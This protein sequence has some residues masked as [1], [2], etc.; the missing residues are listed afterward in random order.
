MNNNIDL[1]SENAQTNDNSHSFDE[2]DIFSSE[3]GSLTQSEDLENGSNDSKNEELE[4]ESNVDDENFNEFALK[5]ISELLINLL[6]FDDKNGILHLNTHF[7]IL[8]Q[9]IEEMLV[10]QK[11]MIKCLEENTKVN[12][13]IAKLLEK[14]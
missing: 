14:K 6:T 2:N 5:H 9:R 7:E 4:N 8:N 11:T 13:L 10:N 1:T 3:S 12:K